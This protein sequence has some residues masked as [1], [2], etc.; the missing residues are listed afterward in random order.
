MKEVQST[1]KE[2][3]ERI[4]AMEASQGHL[5]KSISD[6]KD[7]TEQLVSWAYFSRGGFWVMLGIG[8]VAATIINIWDKIKYMLKG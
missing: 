4:A 8:G 3:G 7:V 1:L 5:S 6:L 2:F